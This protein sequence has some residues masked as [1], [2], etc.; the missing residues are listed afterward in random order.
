MALQEKDA[1]SAAAD[2]LPATVPSEVV[3]QEKDAALVAV[4]HPTLAPAVATPAVA[5]PSEAHPAVAV[6]SAAVR[7]PTLAPVAATPAVAA[8]VPSE[9]VA[10]EVSPAVVVAVPSEA[11]V[12]LAAVAV[13]VAADTSVADAKRKERKLKKS[14]EK[15]TFFIYN[16]NTRIS[17]FSIR[18]TSF[19]CLS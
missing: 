18:F 16:S 1:A 17:P 11:V 8:A 12:T 7:P 14:A 2:R 13:A 19:I 6:P 4:L 5:V 15:L 3:L 9:E 10:Q